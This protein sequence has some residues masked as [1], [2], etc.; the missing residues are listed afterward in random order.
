MQVIKIFMF[1]LLAI[2][3]NANSENKLTVDAI[4]FSAEDQKNLV[5]FS[6]DVKMNRVNDKLYADKL[7]IKLKE[8]IDNSG[9]K[10]P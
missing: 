7:V 6:G 10:E 4:N 2:N 9:T 3:M 1:I 5:V 8:N